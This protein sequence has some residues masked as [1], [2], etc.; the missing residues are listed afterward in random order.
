M[1]KKTPVIFYCKNCNSEINHEL[2]WKDAFLHIQCEKC[3]RWN[4][5]EFENYEV[6]SIDL[7]GLTPKEKAKELVEKFEVICGRTDTAVQYALI[8]IDEMLKIERKYSNFGGVV[9]L[10]EV[11]EEIEKL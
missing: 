5:V 2:Q 6:K 10:Q 1:N 4:I 7:K 3:K 11:K 9:Y 8:C